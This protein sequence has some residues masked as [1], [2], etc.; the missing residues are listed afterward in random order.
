MAKFLLDCI[1]HTR[2]TSDV[3][4]TSEHE[5]MAFDTAAVLAPVANGGS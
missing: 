1:Q 5:R 2:D 3:W 4:W